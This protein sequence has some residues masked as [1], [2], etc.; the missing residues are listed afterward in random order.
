MDV[1]QVAISIMW[2][3]TTFVGL[4]K[5]MA[6]MEELCIC[7]KVAKLTSISVA[8]H[9]SCEPIVGDHDRGLND[10]LA[11][12]FEDCL[13]ED[14]KL[15]DHVTW[16]S[17]RIRFREDIGVVEKYDFDASFHTFMNTDFNS[18][19]ADL[20]TYI[21]FILYIGSGIFRQIS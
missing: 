18:I 20:N 21:V 2:V 11:A 8:G 19:I 13:V 4:L 16:A 1:V 17:I 9:E 15:E 3:N 6:D 14:G 12:I 10:L 5:I 7:E